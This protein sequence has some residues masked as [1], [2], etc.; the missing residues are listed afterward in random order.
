MMWQRTKRLINSYLDGLIERSSSPDREVRQI[1]RAEIARLNEV[2]VQARAAVKMFEKELAEIEL[3]LVG[4]AER[5]RILRERGDALAADSAANDLVALNARRDLLKTQIADANQSAARAQA[6][7]EQR[8]VQSEDLAN[9]THLTSMS[10][11]ISRTQSS[12]DPMDPGA[13]IDEMRDRI[14]A[15]SAP[16][17]DSNV[18]AA[19]RELELE[20]ARSAVDELLARYKRSIE[21]PERASTAARPQAPAAEPEPGVT[22]AEK[23]EEGPG[24]PKSLGRTEG[25]VRPID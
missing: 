18:A 6:L 20:R 16:G 2:E 9:Q 19:D 11:T 21:E 7:R 8:R 25:P 13:T 17:V 15:R 23:R 10:E 22:Q 12:F 1:T 24:Q 5:E 14:N 3:K 4:V